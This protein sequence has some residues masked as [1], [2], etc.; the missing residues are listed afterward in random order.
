MSSTLT[1]DIL[2]LPNPF[3]PLCIYTKNLSFQYFIH[4][5]LLKYDNFVLKILNIDI[6]VIFKT[7]TKK[8]I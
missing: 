5:K 1:T 6:P 7:I 8:N 3:A 2:K 4:I